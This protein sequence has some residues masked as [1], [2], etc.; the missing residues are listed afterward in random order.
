[1]LVIHALYCID[2]VHSISRT[3]IAFYVY[4]EIVK[5]SSDLLNTR[6]VALPPLGMVVRNCASRT[7]LS[8]AAREGATRRPRQS[9]LLPRQAQGLVELDI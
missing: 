3:W 5:P 2:T 9:R 8:H 4:N 1:M 6:V 7:G